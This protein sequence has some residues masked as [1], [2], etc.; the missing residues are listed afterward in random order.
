[1][2]TPPVSAV[3]ALMV[4][5]DLR[6]TEAPLTGA[7]IVTVGGVVSPAGTAYLTSFEKGLC[8]PAAL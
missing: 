8:S 6:G 7:V 4:T 5:V 3:V 2:V 1:M